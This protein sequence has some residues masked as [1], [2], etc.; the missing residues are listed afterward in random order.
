MNTQQPAADEQQKQSQV[1]ASTDE[2]T[3]ISLSTSPTQPPSLAAAVK[4]ADAA[5]VEVADADAD[6]VAVSAE[7]SQPTFSFVVAGGAP[8]AAGGKAVGRR[9]SGLKRHRKN[10]TG[11][12][13][14][15]DE[16]M[17][18]LMIGMAQDEED[19]TRT[20]TRT[21]T[22]LTGTMRTRR[23]TTRRT[24]TRTRT[25][26][27]RTTRSRRSRRC[28]SETTTASSRLRS[29]GTRSGR[30]HASTRSA[31]SSTGTSSR[32]CTWPAEGQGARRPTAAL[33]LRRS[34]E[35]PRRPPASAGCSGSLP[36]RTTLIEKWGRTKRNQAGRGSPET[37]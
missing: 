31:P 28:A 33:V 14:Y 4:V 35:P 8:A 3:T 36:R 9:A 26:T 21:R 37:K 12:A 29:R 11:N 5:A 20:R 34:R 19:E 13:V 22:R 6:A 7:K 1:V 17:V 25:R 27:T 10:D 2:G 15:S 18:K 30:R 23:T 24:R 16:E 32:R